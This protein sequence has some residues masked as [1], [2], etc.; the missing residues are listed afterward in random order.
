M[1]L[2]RCTK[3]EDV[4][5]IH[6]L[7]LKTFNTSAEAD[8]VDR[9]K[10]ASYYDKE[11][12]FVAVSQEKII[13]YILFTRMVIK[14]DKH[15][16]PGLILFPCAVAPEFQKQGV[17]KLLIQ[18]GLERCKY[19]GYK[20]VFASGNNTY[21]NHLGFEAIENYE[22]TPLDENKQVPLVYALSP[23]SNDIKGTIYYPVEFDEFYALKKEMS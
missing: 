23:H 18:K 16:F 11:L 1:T 20:I 4:Q 15:T 10:K 12:S 13:G 22:L 8:L 19:L 6:D 9:L 17:G 3:P 14:N 7:L 21:F 5:A 2:I